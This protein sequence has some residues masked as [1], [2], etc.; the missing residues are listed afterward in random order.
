MANIAFPNMF[1]EASGKTKLVYGTDVYKQ[2]LKCLLLTNMR[3]LFGDPKFG[4][5]IKELIFEP[6]NSFFKVRLNQRLSDISNKLNTINIL[7]DQTE[8][9]EGVGD[10]ALRIVI[11]Y[12][13]GIARGTDTLEITVNNSDIVIE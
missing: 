1:D 4:S 7:T 6:R 13:Y 9:H 10:N 11:Y 3:E 5:S 2:S 12:T 8:V